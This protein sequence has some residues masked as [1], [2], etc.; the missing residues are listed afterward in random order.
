MLTGGIDCPPEASLRAQIVS[1]F[2][3]VDEP[4]EEHLYWPSSTVRNTFCGFKFVEFCLGVGVS[5]LE[6]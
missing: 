2:P 3:D 6:Y 5:P 4:V 1:L